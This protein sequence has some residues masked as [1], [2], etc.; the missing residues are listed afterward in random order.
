MMKQIMKTINR[1]SIGSVL[2]LFAIAVNTSCTKNFDGYNTDPDKATKEQLT[3]D[4]LA[5]GGYLTQMQHQ[6]IPSLVNENNVDINNYQLIFSLMGD[7]YSGHQGTSNSYN[8]NGINNS[9]YSMI[10]SWYGA[11]F[12]NAYKN[13]MAPWY[14]VKERA[15][16]SSP[17]TFA[18]AQTIKVM[19]MHRVTDTYGPLPYLQFKTGNISTPYDSQEAIYD[20][21]FKDLDQS[22]TV[23]T[24]FIQKNPGAK[25]LANFDR[26]YSGDLSM[27]LKLTASLKLRLAMRTVNISPEKSRRYAEEAITTG[28]ML[29]NGD[30]AFLRVDGVSS[31]NPLYAISASYNDTR[32]G[33][34]IESFMKGYNDPRI[35]LLFNRVALPASSTPDYHG[36]RSGSRFPGNS[37]AAFS[38]LNI[39]A[40]T[41]I[42]WMSASEI[43]FL[44]AEGAL[45]GW[46]MGGDAKGLY[47][48]GIRMAFSQPMGGTNGTAGDATSYINDGT[49]TP[50]PYVD[51]INN[52]NSMAATTQITIRWEG[53]DFDTNLER[54]LTQK[55]LALYPDGHEAWSEFRRTGYPKIFPI[56]ASNNMSGGLIST[57]LHV[58]RSP[59]PQNEYLNNNAAVLLGIQLLNGPDHGGTPLW[60]DTRR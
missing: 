38:S 36:I 54:I 41:P 32:M 47:E 8:N 27:W 2:L 35:G 21:F 19:A 60:W 6:V 51:P 10:P 20:S 18:I 37:Y 52:S 5:L 16:M 48:Q 42:K 57:R 24:D 1:Q 11:H 14:A 39:A 7:I 56:P 45:R 17:V 9:T 49:S 43:Y 34:S 58:R 31:T 26:I 13:I 12:L 59:F 55:W 3:K 44:R 53:A 46:N 28:V 15:E 50:A 22:I 29:S 30:N 40:S 23:L 4:N 33:A 25:P